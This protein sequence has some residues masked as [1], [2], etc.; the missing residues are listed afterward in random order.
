MPNLE[1]ADGE[2]KKDGG[3]GKQNRHYHLGLLF[4]PSPYLGTSYSN[5]IPYTII[6]FPFSTIP[7]NFLTM[8]D[9]F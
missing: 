1:G 3:Q 9:D 7:H 2:G 5:I 6:E 4:T 8:P